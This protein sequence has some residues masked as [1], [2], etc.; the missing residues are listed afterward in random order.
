VLL[1][2]ALVGAVGVDV[3]VIGQGRS[4]APNSQIVPAAR[5][6]IRPISFCFASH[7]TGSRLSAAYSVQTGVRE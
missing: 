5:M 4:G 2:I 1:I 3:N 7:L 6:G